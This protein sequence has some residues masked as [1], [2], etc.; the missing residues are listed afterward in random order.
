MLLN[1]LQKPEA[2]RIGENIAGK[3]ENEKPA[4]FL[5]YMLKFRPPVPMPVMN[6]KVPPKIYREKQ[7]PIPEFPMFDK[8]PTWCLYI[9][10][11]KKIK[12]SNLALSCQKK[13]YKMAIVTD[14][15]HIPSFKNVKATGPEKREIL[16]N[17]TLL[18]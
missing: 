11:A 6:M 8:L 12:T 17:I 16:H 10:H 14:D 18:A 3:K 1:Q 2:L 4:Q 9:R 5:I 15:V 7:S 13:N